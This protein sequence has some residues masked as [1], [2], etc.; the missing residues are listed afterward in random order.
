[1]SL[2]TCLYLPVGVPT[3]HLETA[4]KQF[5][6]SLKMLHTLAPDIV[7][8]TEPLLSIESLRAFLDGKHPDLVI[9]Q[10]LTF[11]HAAYAT[12][13]MRL[14]DAPMLLWTLAEPEGDGGRLKL[15]SLT[16]AFSAG[17][18]HKAMRGTPLQYVL[19][20]PDNPTVKT[21]VSAVIAAARVKKSLRSLN[22]AM[23][24]HTP[25]GF[26]FGRAL[27]TEM[28]QVFGVN[29]VAIESREL[30]KVAR[31]LPDEALQTAKETVQSRMLGFD[32]TPRKN[33]D[34]LIRLYEAYRQFVKQHQIGALASRCWPDFFTDYG[35]PVCAVLGM[36]NENR[37]AAA[38]EADAWG[39]LS[40]VIGERLSD[41]PT[42]LGDPVAI[43]PEENTITFWHCGTGPCNL[44][45]QPEGAQT[46]V[47]PN[48]KIGPTMEFGLRA[49]D[50]ATLFRIGRL[51]DGRFRF[52]IHEGAILDKPKQYCGTSLVFKAHTPVEP[53]ITA[54]VKDGFEPHFVVIYDHVA[55]A[56]T[57]LAEMLGLDITK[58]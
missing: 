45:R 41:L 40:M 56:L 7:T 2:L 26:G 50:R 5:Q 51:P 30:T 9:Y 53:L 23:I 13:V 55:E 38:C 32:A 52:F 47:H 25:S 34:D 21:T 48:R 35:T 20:A 6:A 19:G 39:A 18:A 44:A 12:E 17:H 37:V 3:F 58:Y 8:P 14:T 54:L 49:S 42:Y 33:H 22:L 11:A 4:H 29:L 15:N 10:N 24:G 31:E 28:A 36:L 1:M 27:D 46:G 57:I 16:G 43:N